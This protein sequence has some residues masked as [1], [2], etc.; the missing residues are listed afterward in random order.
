MDEYHQF[1][2]QCALSYLESRTDM[3]LVRDHMTLVENR[4]PSSFREIYFRM[5]ESLA[6]KRNMSNSIGEIQELAPILFDF[7][8]QETLKA[9]QTWES[10]FD[11]ARVIIKRKVRMDKSDSHNYW[12]I[13]CKG[14]LSA[15]KYLSRFSTSS[16]FL[17]FVADFDN[18]LHTRPALPLLLGQEIFGYKFALACDL[19]KELG[20][21]N[22]SKP[23]THL[24]YIFSNLGIAD[25]TP[26]DVF[27]TVTSLADEVGE[28][29]YAVDK[30]FWL[31]GSGKLYLNNLTFRTDKA[32]FVN[33]VKASWVKQ[34]KDEEAT[35]VSA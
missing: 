5:L 32:E 13:F 35:K 27:R 23:D 11:T 34:T 26:L 17:D 33:Q 3:K 15:A 25:G 14:C 22:Y 31:I 6:N 7:D 12:V 24:I 28:T 1:I 19:L 8:H 10:L 20:F 18:N 4:K 9:Y 30:V 29:P 16:E 21:S 2:W